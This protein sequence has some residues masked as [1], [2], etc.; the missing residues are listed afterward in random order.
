M[1]NDLP[2]LSSI[3]FGRRSNS[4]LVAC[5]NPYS[6][7]GA[8]SDLTSRGDVRYFLFEFN[9]NQSTICLNS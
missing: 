5:K 2:V 1:S 6:P 9:H 4:A 8:I 7:Y 3:F